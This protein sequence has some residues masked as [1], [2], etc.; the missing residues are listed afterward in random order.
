MVKWWLYIRSI[1]LALRVVVFERFRLAVAVVW[2]TISITISIF[3]AV[4]NP[5]IALVYL[6]VATLM[7]EQIFR[8]LATY[9]HHLIKMGDTVEFIPKQ[10]ESSYIQKFSRGVVIQRVDPKDIEIPDAQGLYEHL[11]LLRTA[12]ETVIVAFE[13]IVSIE[14]ESRL[15]I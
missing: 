15:D 7:Y 5:Y 4:I 11:F 2:G 14:I 6:L 10:D 1:L 12:K 3:I 8:L 13:H 9:K